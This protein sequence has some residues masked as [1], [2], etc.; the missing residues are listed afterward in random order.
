MQEL[1]RASVGAVVLVVANPAA[2]VT[3]FRPCHANKPLRIVHSNAAMPGAELD[4]A[5]DLPVTASK[6][7]KAFRQGG[8]RQ[9]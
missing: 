1:P 3:A 5:G 8:M 7:Q 4:E 6:K 2:F 9:R